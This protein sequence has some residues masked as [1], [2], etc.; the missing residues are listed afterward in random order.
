MDS[1]LIVT[2]T[3]HMDIATGMASDLSEDLGLDAHAVRIDDL[4]VR[5]QSIPSDRIFIVPLTP[6]PCAFT[7]AS[8]PSALNVEEGS[9]EFESE[10]KSILITD[11]FGTHPRI[12][13]V[14]YDNV[15]P[16]EP[17]AGTTCIVMVGI[18]EDTRDDKVALNEWVAL[19]RGF[20]ID[21]FAAFHGGEPSP[22]SCFDEMV[23]LGYKHMVVIPTLCEIDVSSIEGIDI[24]L[25]NDLTSYKGVY[26][27]VARIVE[28]AIERGSVLPAKKTPMGTIEAPDIQD[29]I[30]RMRQRQQ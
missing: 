30:Q 21:A 2:D 6:A 9:R 18:D 29:L 15:V 1:V 14:L 20:N 5:I 28:K 22:G 25:G 8:I 7:E 17:E 3:R 10:G 11:T 16:L 19:I 23:S 27:I 13:D 12:R 24:I 4:K 26:D